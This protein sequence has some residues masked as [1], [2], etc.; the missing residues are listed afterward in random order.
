MGAM[1][2]ELQPSSDQLE[3]IFGPFNEKYCS[4]CQDKSWT[5]MFDYLKD[6]GCCCKCA[7]HF[8]YYGF[9]GGRGKRIVIKQE[10]NY[11]EYNYKYDACIT[12]YPTFD[13]KYGFFDYKNKRCSIPRMYRSKTCLGFSCKNEPDID[14]PLVNKLVDKIVDIRFKYGFIGE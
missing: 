1:E 6:T 13:N 2:E 10:A 14:R 8:G 5:T 4:N 9:K 11:Y 12:R 3:A 7:S